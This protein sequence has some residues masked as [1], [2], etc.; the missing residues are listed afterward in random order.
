MRPNDLMH[1]DFGVHKGLCDFAIHKGLCD[2]KF[3]FAHYHVQ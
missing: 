2:Q 3:K 1:T